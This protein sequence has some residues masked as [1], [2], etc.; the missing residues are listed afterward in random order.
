MVIITLSASIDTTGNAVAAL[1]VNHIHFW[2][3]DY[4]T[5]YQAWRVGCQITCTIDICDN[6]RT[7]SRLIVEHVDGNLAC[8]ITIDITTTEGV[9]HGT[10]IE[11][12]GYIACYVSRDRL[13]SLR[14]RVIC[15]TLRATENIAISAAINIERDIACDIGLV[16]AAVEV[17]Y[18]NI[19]AFIT[20]VKSGNYI[21]SERGHVSTT[22]R[23]VNHHGFAKRINRKLYDVNIAFTVT[24]TENLI[25]ETSLNICS[26]GAINISSWIVITSSVTTTEDSIETSTFDDNVS[27]RRNTTISCSTN[28]SCVSTAI[29]RF[30]RV[31]I[32]S[33]NVNCGTMGRIAS[34][35]CHGRIVSQ[36]TAAIY[37]FDGIS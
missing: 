31:F 28:I 1:H 7:G 21:A 25:E 18:D 35:R 9:S 17:T 29:Y 30:H 8:D 10:A 27:V 2:R 5:V 24:A 11:V 22:E 12:K 3:G 19:I 37:R 23:L 20:T 34:R 26:S 15:Y 6:K 16:R 36:I 14:I 13:I 33:I 4:L 32:T